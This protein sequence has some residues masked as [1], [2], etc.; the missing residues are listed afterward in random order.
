MLLLSVSPAHAGSRALQPR[1][2]LDRGRQEEACLNP[3]RLLAADAGRKEPS[4]HAPCIVGT[5]VISNTYAT[6]PG[7]ALI[8]Q[9]KCHTSTVNGSH[10]SMIWHSV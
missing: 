2:C 1:L 4:S 7:S 9:H 8:C 5:Q 6:L 10:S 3:S